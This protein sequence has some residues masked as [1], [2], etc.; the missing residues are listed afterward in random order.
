MTYDARAQQIRGVRRAHETEDVR[1]LTAIIRLL[2]K[3]TAKDTP[4][5]KAY[6]ELRKAAKKLRQ[7]NEPDLNKLAGQ[8]EQGA[9]SLKDAIDTGSRA[10]DKIDSIVV[11][12]KKELQQEKTGRDED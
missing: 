2:D 7:M 6:D 1:Q 10:Y 8:L 12:V 9:K 11:K 3:A 4:T 5:V